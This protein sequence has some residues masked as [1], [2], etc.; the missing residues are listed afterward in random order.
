MATAVVTSTAMTTST[1]LHHASQTVAPTQ[2][3]SP[4]IVQIVEY[5]S[6]SSLVV[7]SFIGR[8]LTALLRNVVA[9]FSAILVSIYTP[10]SF[11]L[12]PLFLFLRIAL[13][14]LILTPWSILGNV[15]VYLYPL[16]LFV[17]TSCIAAGL[18]GL[19]ARLV[20]N[21]IK[22]VMVSPEPPSQAVPNP[23]KHVSIKEEF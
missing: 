6:S 22:S 3:T 5:L 18:V 2:P 16:Y 8:S 23:R 9:P 19:A 4:P 20:A 10:L 13:N 1:I 21:F 15:L 7:I 17:G 14:A 12:A 11:I